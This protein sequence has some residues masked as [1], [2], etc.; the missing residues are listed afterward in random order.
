MSSILSISPLFRAVQTDQTNAAY[1]TFAGGATNCSQ[2]SSQ[3]IYN[4]SSIAMGGVS[5]QGGGGMV[6]AT[7]QTDS[8]GSY[9][10]QSESAAGYANAVGSS[11]QSM[12]QSYAS[13]SY[14]NSQYV[15]GMDQGGSG[16]MT[17]NVA[18]AQNALPQNSM[19]NLQGDTVSAVNNYQ[20]QS[21]YRYVILT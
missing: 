13:Q 1:D 3:S 18:M 9:A 16:T 15:Q 17:Q 7:T 11:Y 5:S 6:T 14:N 2:F 21:S 4:E 12:S 10:V 8:G 19:A 20:H